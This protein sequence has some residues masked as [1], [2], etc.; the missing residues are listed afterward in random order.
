MKVQQTEAT[1]LWQAFL[2]KRSNIQ[3]QCVQ[4]L[5]SLHDQLYILTERDV[6]E[7]NLKKITDVLH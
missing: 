1:Q 7:N 2:Q 5:K 6:L 4:A 3:Q